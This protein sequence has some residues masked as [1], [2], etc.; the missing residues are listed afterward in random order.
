MYPKSLEKLINDFSKLPGVGE[1][2]AQRYAV[3]LTTNLT[4]EE[5][6]NFSQNINAIK[7]LKTCNI[8]GNIADSNECSICSNQS[9]DHSTIMIVADIKD[10]FAFENMRTFNGIYHVLGGLIDLSKGITP[11]DLKIDK[12]LKRLNGVVE[13]IIST[14]AT[15]S[16]EI[17]AKYLKNILEDKNIQI[18]RLA[19]GLPVGS[20]FKYADSLTLSKAIQNRQKY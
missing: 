12:L 15:V 3:Y 18:T 1:K 11:N 4:K 20:D 14:N 16:G 17:T 13:I 9:K 2:T 5:L 6:E 8:C 10:I 7:D 19:Y